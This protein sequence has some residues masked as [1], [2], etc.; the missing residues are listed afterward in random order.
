MGS[1]RKPNW[2]DSEVP[3]TGVGCIVSNGDHLR[4][5]PGALA[6]AMVDSGA[7]VVA[8]CNGKVKSIRLVTAASSHA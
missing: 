3:R 1:Q 5:I 8:N 4:H 6:A 7:A 2:E